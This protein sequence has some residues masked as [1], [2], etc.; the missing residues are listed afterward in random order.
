MKPLTSAQIR[1]Y[2]LSDASPSFR[3]CWLLLAVL[4]SF[5]CKN[6][7][8]FKQEYYPGTKIVKSE[9]SFAD[10]RADSF[11]CLKIRDESYASRIARFLDTVKNKESIDIGELFGPPNQKYIDGNNEH[12]RYGLGRSQKCDIIDSDACYFEIIRIDKKMYQT[13]ITCQ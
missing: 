5:N 11:G 2:R 12:F 7:R 1:A 8:R 6:A 9:R 3:L 4:T 13:D 10:W